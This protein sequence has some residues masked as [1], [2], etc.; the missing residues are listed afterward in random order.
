MMVEEEDADSL[1]CRVIESL[2]MNRL[3]SVQTNASLSMCSLQS[4][5]ADCEFAASLPQCS[6]GSWVL[7]FHKVAQCEK[8]MAYIEEQCEVNVT[9]NEILSSI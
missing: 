8:F 1:F 5:C 3:K 6:C 4:K 7:H 9:V 2:P